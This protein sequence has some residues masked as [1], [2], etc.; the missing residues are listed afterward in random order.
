MLQYSISTA[1]GGHLSVVWP[2]LQITETPLPLQL[3]GM[4]N[5]V[6]GRNASIEQCIIAPLSLSLA[7]SHLS[8]ILQTSPAVQ[9]LSSHSSPCHRH[10]RPPTP[11]HVPV[12]CP[13]HPTRAHRGTPCPLD[14]SRSTWP[15]RHPRSWVSRRTAGLSTATSRWRPGE[16]ARQ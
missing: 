9:E 4:G 14:A 7:F 13:S 16:R 15:A 12:R 3:Q 11:A 2:T 5:F 8:F 6:K 10:H 1:N